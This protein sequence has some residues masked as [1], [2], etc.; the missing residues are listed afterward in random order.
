MLA[1]FS[2]AVAAPLSARAQDTIGKRFFPDQLIVPEPFVEDELSLPALVYVR[3][4]TSIGIELKKRITSD[5][6]A[7]AGSAYDV[8]SGDSDSRTSGFQNLELGLK[9]QFFESAT[10]EAVA[11]VALGWDVGGTGSR[12][13]GAASFDTVSAG[14]LAGKG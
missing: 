8:V 7:S 6:E 3:P 5:L 14:L 4:T 2:I 12:S 9:Y 10:H 11:S 13:A 1:C